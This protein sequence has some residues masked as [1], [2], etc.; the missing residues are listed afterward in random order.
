MLPLLGIALVIV[1]FALRL[2]PLLVVTAAGV[3]TGLAAHFPLEK[4]LTL[5]GESFIKNRYLSLIILTFPVISLLERHGLREHARNWIVRFKTMSTGRLL[6][7][8]LMM[9]EMFAM[10]GMTGLGGHAQMV[11]PVIAPMAEAAAENRHGE[12]T[13]A[14]Q[15]RIRSLAA[16]C[17]NVGLF[18]GEDIFIAFGAVLLMKGLLDENGIHLQPLD[19]AL[20][21]LPTAI[22]ALLVHGARMLLLERALAR[23]SA[24]LQ[25]L[26]PEQVCE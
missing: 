11:R 1:G 4:I 17:D 24:R 15:H 12:L 10:L 14:T 23:E 5:F 3:V 26:S 25:Q 6:L 13:E 7:F 22:V 21:G 18:F 20:W 9:R 8:Y 19:I 2:N 16:A